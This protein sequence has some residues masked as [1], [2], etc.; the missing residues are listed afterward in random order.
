MAM[1]DRVKYAFLFAWYA[2]CYYL[3]PARP[4]TIQA[5]PPGPGEVIDAVY[6]GHWCA[7]QGVWN[8]K[9][10][11]YQ[12]RITFFPAVFPAGTLFEWTWPS[13]MN[14]DTVYSY[15]CIA[16][17]G[18]LATSLKMLKNL[19]VTY[20]VFVCAD[21]NDYDF[22]IETWV[23]DASGQAKNE[24]G[25]YAH[26]PGYLL[27]YLMTLTDRFHYSEGGLNFFIA[28]G[29]GY[30]AGIPFTQIVP[31]TRPGGTKPVDMFSGTIPF[32]GIL[33]A[34][35]ARG[36]VNGDHPLFNFQCGFET[37][38]NKGWARVNQISWLWE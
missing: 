13:N 24:V 20:D 36:T 2:A 25:F 15:P 18:P 31:V 37:G 11:A 10:V 9:G 14:V 4:C 17:N 19:T 38:R 6:A 3:T 32:K 34:L 7:T 28:T 12:Q 35:I 33:D 1:F 22:L 29:P 5:P 21:P 23:Y 26:V 16:F 30:N 8:A 27:M